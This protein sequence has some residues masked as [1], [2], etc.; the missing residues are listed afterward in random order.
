MPDTYIYP[1]VFTYADDGISVEFPDLPGC[2]TCGDNDAEA[3]RMAKDAL[4]GYLLTSEEDGEPIPAPTSAR[5]I[6]LAEDERVQLVEAFMPPYRKQ[7]GN[8]AVKKT[9]TIPQWMDT[10]AK[11][12]NINFSQ[13]LQDGI[14]ALLLDRQDGATL[15]KNT[16]AM[17][18]S[19]MENVKKGIVYGPVDLSDFE[20]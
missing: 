15:R 20:E 3:L 9:L 19:S 10:A 16:L 4:S 11:Q 6:P 1:A 13:V 7:Y 17:I 14:R 12:A 2:L 18:D 5:D 8:R